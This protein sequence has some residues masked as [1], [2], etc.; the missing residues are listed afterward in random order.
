MGWPG[1]A[2][3]CQTTGSE[4]LSEEVS[5]VDPFQTLDNIVGIEPV[6]PV[7]PSHL[8]LCQEHCRYL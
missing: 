5:N 4:A 7:G 2:E 8:K 3:R 6:G 1:W